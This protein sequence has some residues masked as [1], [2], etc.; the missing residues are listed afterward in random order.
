MFDAESFVGTLTGAY[1][2]FTDDTFREH[3]RTQ[4]SQDIKGSH[5]RFNKDFDGFV[6]DKLSI[7]ASYADYRAKQCEYDPVLWQMRMGEYD[8]H[9]RNTI[10]LD[11]DKTLSESIKDSLS[12]IKQEQKA[13]RE[14][15]LFSLIESYQNGKFQYSGKHEEYDVLRESITKLQKVGLQ[16]SQIELVVNGVIDDKTFISKVWADFNYVDE[17]TN[18]RNMILTYIAQECPDDELT[19]LDLFAL[20]SM[21]VKKVLKE[22]FNNDKKAMK[23]N[24]LWGAW[25]EY[26]GGELAVKDKCQVKVINRYITLD[27]PERNRTSTNVMYKCFLEMKKQEFYSTHKV[28]YTNLT[29]FSIDKTII[30]TQQLQKAVSDVIAIKK[31][32]L[33]LRSMA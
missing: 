16:D 24:K 29:G 9:Y 11:G 28:K 10:V 12:K 3:F 18:I 14:E 1:M 15:V 32:F 17:H 6:I 33:A 30:S 25:L 23:K 21:I 7:N 13:E 31:G 4:Y 19:K 5:V 22:L 8:F 26:Q 2:G 20:T 27:K